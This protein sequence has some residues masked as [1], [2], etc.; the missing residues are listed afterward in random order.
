MAKKIF[1]CDERI[2]YILAHEKYDKTRTIPG[3][4]FMIDLPAVNNDLETAT[5]GLTGLGFAPS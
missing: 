4:E 5:R 1:A 3:F 2:A